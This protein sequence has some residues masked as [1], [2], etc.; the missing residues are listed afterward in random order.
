MLYCTGLPVDTITKK[1]PD[2][3]EQGDCRDC[4]KE[5]MVLFK[6]I[7]HIYIKMRGFLD[8]VEQMTI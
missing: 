3:V 6:S 4:R 5:D 8:E 7:M 2:G 1:S